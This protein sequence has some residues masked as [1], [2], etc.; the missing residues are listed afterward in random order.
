MAVKVEKL[1]QEKINIAFV[2]SPIYS[3]GW[4]D[5]RDLVFSTKASNTEYAFYSFCKTNERIDGVTFVDVDFHKDLN[6]MTNSLKKNNIDVALLLS[7]WPETYSF[8]Y[9]ECLCANCFVL[10][11]NVSGNIKRQVG[12]RG[13]GKIFSSKEEIVQYLSSNNFKNDLDIFFS[14]SN[15]EYIAQDDSSFIRL[16]KPCVFN[17]STKRKMLSI[18]FFYKCVYLLKQFFRQNG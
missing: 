11:Y 18:S 15:K 16:L 1:L 4:N 7:K 3:K 17:C 5:F 13:N 6:A 12:E 10:C 8:T 14:K 9:Y 2:G